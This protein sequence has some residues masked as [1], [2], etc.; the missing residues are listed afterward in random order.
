ME[1]YVFGVMKIDGHEEQI[2]RVKSDTEATL[3]EGCYYEIVDESGDMIVTNTFKA[4]RLI[5]SKTDSN[6]NHYSW[7]RIT[8]HIKTIDRSPAAA[9]AAEQNA[10]LIDY[11]SMMTGIDLPG[12]D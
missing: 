4:G 10:A 2:V 5:E 7:Y 12:I 1:Q 3:H 9:K 6:M 8:E 11:I